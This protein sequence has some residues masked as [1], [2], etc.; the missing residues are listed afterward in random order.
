[1]KEPNPAD[2]VAGRVAAF[3]R[4]ARFLAVLTGSA[5][6]AVLLGWSTGEDV[7]KSVHADLVAMNPATAIAFVLAAA[8]LWLSVPG[9][10]SRSRGAI[11][12]TAALAVLA[13]AILR[14]VGYLGPDLGVDSLLFRDRLDAEAIP[15]RM[16]PNTAA[17][18]LLSGFALL[19]LRSRSRATKGFTQALSLLV[20][21]IA[22]VTLSGYA[23][24]S[25]NLVRVRQ[26][27]P[28]ALHT[29]TA[30]AFLSFGTL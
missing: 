15:N 5:G 30:F 7:L 10:G 25:A 16:A 4:F 17:A 24:H 20:F 3:E 23:Y 28:M 13:I 12:T 18:F 8:S 6:L 11:A 14:L 21:A 2:A 22:L 9:P 1:M 27:I 26:F 19:G 29:A